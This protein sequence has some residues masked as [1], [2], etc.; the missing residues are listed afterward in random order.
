MAIIVNEAVN[1]NHSNPLITNEKLR[2]LY[3]TMLKCR[4]LQERVQILKKPTRSNRG[5]CVAIGNEA[6]TVGAGIHLLPQDAVASSERDFILDFIKGAPLSAIFGHLRGRGTDPDNGLLTSKKSGKSRESSSRRPASPAHLNIGAGLAVAD[7]LRCTG[8]VAIA[9]LGQGSISVD[10]LNEALN[11]GGV[12]KLP[13]VYVWQSD[14]GAKSPLPKIHAKSEDFH[15][16]PPDSSFP[17]I[18][19]DGNDVVAMYRVAQEAIERARSGGGPTLIEAKKYR[20]ATDLANDFDS[21]DQKY[22]NDP[23]AAMERYLTGK[24]LFSTAWRQEVSAE[25]H[26]ELDLAMETAERTP[27]EPIGCLNSLSLQTI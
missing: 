27:R 7:K 5:F 20:C 19:V 2:Q 8:N 26:K 13:V 11:F 3:S 9:F 17:A 4:L 23:I 6:T 24:G 12:R 21:N 22:P 25:F 14:L 18:A 10:A 15:L 1:A 16:N